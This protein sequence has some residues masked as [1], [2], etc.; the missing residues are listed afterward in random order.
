MQDLQLVLDF[1]MAVVAAFF[2]GIIAQRLRQPVLLGYLVGGMLIGPFTPGPRADLHSVEAMAEIGVAFL[3]FALGAEFSIRELARLG[4]VAVIGG[5][6]QMGATALLGPVLAPALGLTPFQGWFLGA[7][8]ALSST[9]VALKLLL[10]RGET[11]A[12]HGRLAF[13]I[14]L[15]QDLAVVPMVVVLPVLGSGGDGVLSSLAVAAAEAVVVLLGA[16]LVG[17]RAAPWLLSHAALP[18]SRELFLL[19]V[20]SLALG[21]A[22]V[23][24]YIGLSLA[25]G[26]FLAG[27]VISESD[28]KTRVVAEVLPLRDLF[29]SLFFV[30]VGMLIDPSALVVQAGV[31]GLV[32]LGTILVK[33]AATT[34][35]VALLGFPARVGLLVGLSL[36]QVGEFSFVLARIG[37]ATG[38]IPTELF[39]VV[40]ATSVLTILL[41]P[42]LLRT[43]PSLLAWLTRLPG[44]GVWFRQPVKV[45]ADTAS[46]RRHTVICGYGNVARELADV[47]ERRG[48]PYL[49]IEYHPEVVRMLRERGVPVI[50]GDA[51]NPVV[52]DHA[53]LETAVLLAVLVPDSNTA[54]LATRYARQRHPRLDIVTRAAA[55]SDLEQ[56]L[57][58]GATEVVQPEFEAGVEVIRHV[59]QR[60]GV[61]GMELAGVTSGRR[62]AFYRRFEDRGMS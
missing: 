27:L 24:R 39:A 52:L 7:L 54:E 22:L 21:T 10:E 60:Y 15:M 41:S 33:V 25:F 48:F 3:M 4:R 51:A 36:A 1:V 37:V 14:L 18:R 42:F 6:V 31:V 13:G 35:I 12:V 8:L 50:Y 43:S 58:A 44:A 30:S 29:I 5:A 2:G 56:L 46:L 47:L 40:L 28:F 26:A 11:Q 55:P 23:T 59:L 49:V 57:A 20:V 53:H 38:A 9:V 19:G 34:L 17:A 16:Y 61:G 62:N 45:E 32:A